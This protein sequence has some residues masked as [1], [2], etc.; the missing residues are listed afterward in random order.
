MSSPFGNVAELFP[1][2]RVYV[3]GFDVTDDVLACRVECHDGRAPNVCEIE[4][5]NAGTDGFMATDSGSRSS[6]GIDRYII[7]PSDIHA[8]YDDV[9]LANIQLPGQQLSLIDAARAAV[10]ERM[11]YD[12]ATADYFIDEEAILSGGATVNAV[13]ADI[14][15]KY[16]AAKLQAAVV[17]Y[18][19]DIYREVRQRLERTIVDPVKRAVLLSKF[20]IAQEV[21]QPD[22]NTTGTMPTSTPRFLALQGRAHRYPFQVG[23]CVFHSNDPVRVFWRDPMRPKL[24]YHMFAGFVTDWVD[25]VNEDNDRVVTLRCEDVSRILRYARVTTNPGLFDIQYVRQHPDAVIHTWYNYGAANLTLPEFLFT[26][27]FGT[28]DT[29]VDLPGIDLPGVQSFSYTR[30]QPFS[31]DPVT[32]FT[33]ADAIG[34]F[35]YD[36]SFVALLPISGP[37]PKNTT[38]AKLRSR[39]IDIRDLAEYQALLD[40]EVRLADLDNMVARGAF[41]TARAQVRMYADGSAEIEDVVNAI[42]TNPA[43]YP[44][45]GGRVIMLLPKSLGVADRDLLLRDLVAPA[46]QTTWTTRLKLIYDLVERIEFS[47]YASPRG[48]IICEMPLHDFQPDDFGTT[49]PVS[50]SRLAVQL[51]LQGDRS[52]ADTRGPFGPHYVIPR[53]ETVEWDRSFSDEHVRTVVTG[54]DSVF[55]AYAQ[56]GDTGKIGQQPQ[57][58]RREALFPQFGVRQEQV[59]SRG[60]IATPE[61]MKLY[62]E[63][64]LNRLNADARS[65]HMTCLPRVQLMWPNRPLEFEARSFVATTR[66]VTHAIRWGQDIAST[67]DVNYQ[68]GWSGQVT[69]AGRPIYEPLGGMASKPLNYALMWQ[70]DRIAAESSK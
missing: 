63:L 70:G 4:L 5:T 40:H 9:D 6:A 21:S 58:A 18:S 41:S 67:L 59:D 16:N 45:D 55:K 14:G 39:F 11:E 62:C 36:R 10:A 56:T 54:N 44:V 26:L 19:D 22:F 31:G 32:D 13:V 28:T 35:N 43:L 47:F 65:A 57:V 42:G 27:I 20:G 49:S 12:G 24:W 50:L 8:L 68:R 46:T 29:G 7:E 34:A 52:T 51:D 23:D 25:R 69:A 61:G 30:Y 60:L 37:E 64:V 33:V 38:A 1:A 2:Y 15:A 48:D 53:A 17:E 3:A 66:K